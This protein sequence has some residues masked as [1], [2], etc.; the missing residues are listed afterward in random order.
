MLILPVTGMFSANIQCRLLN[1]LFIF[2][3][4]DLFDHDGNSKLPEQVTDFVRD[5]RIY[6]GAIPVLQTKP[7]AVA[8]FNQVFVPGHDGPDSNSTFF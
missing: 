1:F 7:T 2:L 4:F 5:L 6:H 3:Q 8:K